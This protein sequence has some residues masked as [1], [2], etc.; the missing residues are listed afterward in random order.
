MQFLRI[1]WTNFYDDFIV[2]S[3]PQLE[4][5]TGNAVASLLKLLG[6]VFATVTSGKKAAPFRTSCRALGIK[7]DLTQSRAGI[8]ELVNTEER[9]SEL[10][11]LLNDVISEKVISGATAR[12]LHGRMVF[13]DAQLF[14]RTGKR[15]MQVLSRYSQRGKSHL[16]S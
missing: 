12:G 14:E 3:D 4:S 2:L 5:N 6:W 9:V 13:A 10:C 1:V 16:S 11:S 8:A 7:F 15:C